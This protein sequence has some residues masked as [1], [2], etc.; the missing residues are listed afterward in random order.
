MVG[1]ISSCE[2]HGKGGI[3]RL[4]RKGAALQPV[5]SHTHAQRTGRQRTETP[6][7]WDGAIYIQPAPRS[8][9]H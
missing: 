6:I 9:S 1:A 5:A 3:C 7:R 8:I 4:G 2:D